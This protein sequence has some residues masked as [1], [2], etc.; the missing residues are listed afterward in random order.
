[1]GL[2]LVEIESG[3]LAVAEVDLVLEVVGADAEGSWALAVEHFDARLHAFGLA[4]RGIVTQ[5]DGGG[6][7]Q[8]DEGLADDVA[9]QVH[10][11]GQRLDAE[12]GAVA[13]DDEA[14]QAVAFAP[15]EAA[16]EF[17]EAAAAA[18]LDGLADAAGEEIQVEVLAAAGEAAGDDLG[19]RVIDRGAERAVAKILEGDHVAGLGVAESFLDLGGVNPL[20]AVENTGAGSDDEACHGTG[21]WGGRRGLSNAKTA[22][23]KLFCDLRLIWRHFGPIPVA[24]N[25]GPTIE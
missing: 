7:E 24:T 1:M 18:M 8:R 19:V 2:D 20:V 5:D 16:E 10:G 13:I 3:F 17:I 14:G 11:Q 23:D 6:G 12:V 4:E 9:A 22:A 25:H 21:I 15:D